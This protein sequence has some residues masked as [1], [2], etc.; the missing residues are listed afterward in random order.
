MVLLRTRSILKRDN[1]S[2]LRRRDNSSW[3][4]LRI[5]GLLLRGGTFFLLFR[6]AYCMKRRS[7]T[8]Y[9]TFGHF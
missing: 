3:L 5:R 8:D 6:N 4:L 1:S 2:H 9:I 7:G